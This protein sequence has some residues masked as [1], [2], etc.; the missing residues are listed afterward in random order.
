MTKNT[1]T[2]RPDATTTRAPLYATMSPTDRIE[3]IAT[4]PAQRAAAA[5]AATVTPPPAPLDASDCVGKYPPYAKTPAGKLSAAA[6]AALVKFRAEYGADWKTALNAAWGGWK[7]NGGSMAGEDRGILRAVRNQFGPS[8]L[9]NL[10]K[11]ELDSNL[12]GETLNG[13]TVLTIEAHTNCVT[14]MVHRPEDSYNPFV[15]A[16]WWRGLGDSWSWGHYCEDSI[17]ARRVFRDVADRNAAR[18]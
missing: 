15:V 6:A 7:F 3:A 12:P 4:T 18:L 2:A 5:T 10:T 11:A 14:V 8:W 1:T 9:S 13:L 17:E 16:T